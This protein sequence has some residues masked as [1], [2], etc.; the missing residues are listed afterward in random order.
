M[1]LLAGKRKERENM[2]AATVR[3][4]FCSGPAMVISITIL[5]I[6]RVINWIACNINGTQLN[7]LIE[8]NEIYHPKSLNF[9]AE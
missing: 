9:E 6:K 4:I 7:A 1:A 2:V 3:I 8:L 5:C